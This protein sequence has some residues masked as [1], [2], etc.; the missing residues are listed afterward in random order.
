MSTDSGIILGNFINMGFFAG[1][2]EERWTVSF[3][4]SFV[5]TVYFVQCISGKYSH[6]VG[7][8]FL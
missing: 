5:S 7:S 1:R 2:G 8:A 6:V 4:L 3:W